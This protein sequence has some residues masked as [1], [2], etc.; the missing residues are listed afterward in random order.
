MLLLYK[1]RY[2]ILTVYYYSIF[3]GKLIP[4][5]ENGALSVSIM[6]IIAVTAERYNAICHP[7]KRN[8][9]CTKATATRMAVLIWILGF[10][11]CS[12]FMIMTDSEK[13][14][15]YDGTPIE[16]CRT[17]VDS[18]WRYIYIVV[19]FIM[20]FMVPVFLL[21]YMY[22]CTI[23]QLVSDELNLFHAVNTRSAV[24]TLRTRKQVVR[25]LI[26]I[27]ILFFI[28]LCPFRIVTLW[29]IFTPTEK[30]IYIG[31]EGYLNL[32]SFSRIMMYINSAGNPIIYSLTSTKFKAAFKRVLRSTISRSSFGT[33]RCIFGPK[34]Q[35]KA[36][37]LQ[38]HQD[39]ELQFLLEAKEVLS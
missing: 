21:A 3:S 25:M 14:L 2:I 39:Q 38:I 8:I 32:M 27:V 5:L 24:L 19:A 37:V 29:L 9:T 30:V 22:A 6:T 15:F 12:P 20:F 16:V 10:L 18:L 13:A 23:R 11:L 28:S 31:L 7:F 34:K 4:L 36:M 26:F 17:R 33:Q 35:G 1:D